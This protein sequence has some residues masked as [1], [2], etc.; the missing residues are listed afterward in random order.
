MTGDEEVVS[1]DGSGISGRAQFLLDGDIAV[2]GVRKILRGHFNQS[3]PHCNEQTGHHIFAYR[4]KSDAARLV[5][6]ST[7]M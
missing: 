4:M 1:L 6:L 7:T 2:P 5:T 3:Y